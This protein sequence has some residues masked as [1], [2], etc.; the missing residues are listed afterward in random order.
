MRFRHRQYLI[1]MLSPGRF[2]EAMQLWIRARFPPAEL[3]SYMYSHYARR[4][5][6]HPVTEIG[7]SR[8][9]HITIGR[10][11]AWTGRRQQLAAPKSPR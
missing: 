8:L 6:N 5:G 1:G 7:R 11:K 2:I 9:W 3:L 10:M 4:W